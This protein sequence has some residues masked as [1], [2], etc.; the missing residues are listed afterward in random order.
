[1]IKRL[2]TLDKIMIGKVKGAL[3]DDFNEM[4]LRRIIYSSYL[5]SGR[6]QMHNDSKDKR[7]YEEL[8]KFML[9]NSEFTT[10]IINYVVVLYNSRKDSLD[11]DYINE[12]IRIIEEKL[13]SFNKS[14]PE[15]YNIVGE[16]CRNIQLIKH[17]N[18]YKNYCLIKCVDR[19]YG[20][21]KGL[22][23]LKTLINN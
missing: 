17:K 21:E 6:I 9:A 7:E 22:N 4:E 2:I 12:G 1:M 3:K 14:F 10:S 15:G 8:K 5:I 16:S 20:I 11:Y 19:L 18:N 23:S 13:S